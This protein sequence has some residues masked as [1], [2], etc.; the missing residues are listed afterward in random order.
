MTFE[1]CWD[2]DYAYGR[3]GELQINSFLEW[4]ASGNGRVETKRKSW[5]DFCVYVE[6]HCDYGRRGYE[7]SGI[8]VTK[9]E[10][11]AFVIG[12]TGL[13][14]VVPTELLREALQDRSS[15]DKEETHGSHPTKGRLVNLVVILRRLAERQKAR[16]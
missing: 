8:S 14:V 3:Q 4:I 6:T 7:P 13:A 15:V 5:I 1:P 11:W 2:R 9:A 10:A 12:D 16:R